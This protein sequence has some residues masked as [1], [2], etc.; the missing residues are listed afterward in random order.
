M[1][2]DNVAVEKRKKYWG[3]AESGFCWCFWSS[4]F[5]IF[6]RK[7]RSSL[8]V[9]A[10][11][12]SFLPLTLRQRAVAIRPERIATTTPN[13]VGILRSTR[14]TQGIALQGPWLR[15]PGT[16]INATNWSATE[17][18]EVAEAAKSVGVDDVLIQTQ[19]A[20]Y[21]SASCKILSADLLDKPNTPSISSTKVYNVPNKVQ[22]FSHPQRKRKRKLPSLAFDW[23]WQWA[24]IQKHSVSSACF[25]CLISLAL[26]SPPQEFISSGHVEP[27]KDQCK[28]VHF[29]Q[30][31]HFQHL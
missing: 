8:E 24:S 31:S 6:F 20:V 2:Q 9:F 14:L 22:C 29:V 16:A 15:R 30:C 10:V 25:L 19:C 21:V 12:S 18:A 28:G 11:F 5:W 7:F 3:F 1:F 17:T 26:V 13:E 27:F 4:F 23:H